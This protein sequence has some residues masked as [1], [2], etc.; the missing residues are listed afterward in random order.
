MA[1]LR[2]MP[3]FPTLARLHRAKKLSDMSLEVHLSPARRHLD[4]LCQSLFL[5]VTQASFA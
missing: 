2:V 1:F 5:L 4:P 3:A